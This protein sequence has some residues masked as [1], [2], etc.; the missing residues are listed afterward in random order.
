MKI[1]CRKSSVGAG[2]SL[3]E[4]LVA[5][6]VLSIVMVVLLSTLTTSLSLWRNTEKKMAAGR[7]GRAANLLLAQDLANIV[8]TTNTNFWPTVQ[9]SGGI[10]SLRFL[11]TKPADYQ[12]GGAGNFGDV[13]FIEYGVRTADNVL[14]RNFVGSARTY[15]EVLQAGS[16]PSAFDA[17]RAQVLATNLIPGNRDAVREAAWA[18]ELGTN[19]FVLL[20]G[21]LMSSPPGSP[22]A[23]AAIEVTMA[24]AD[25][26]AM[27]NKD[28]WA[29]SRDQLRNAGIY[30]FRLA[31]PPVIP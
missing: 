4:V 26:D 1:S 9:T 28:L 6:A 18:N 3:I 30:S 14:L 16:F 11:A 17:G 25:P 8:M 13:C 7:E 27:A 23:P 2:F 20:G 29:T 24:F 31:L 22:V 5:S 12:S 15:T 19:Y 10:V 21:N